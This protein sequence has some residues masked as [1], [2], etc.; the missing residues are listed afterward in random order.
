MKILDHCSVLNMAFARKKTLKH[1]TQVS[2]IWFSDKNN[3]LAKV[4]KLLTSGYEILPILNGRQIIK[5]KH[6]VNVNS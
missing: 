3:F 2:L 4:H 1:S 6:N 5:L